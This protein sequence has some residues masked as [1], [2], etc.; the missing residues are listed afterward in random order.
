MNNTPMKTKTTKQKSKEPFVPDLIAYSDLQPVHVADVKDPEFVSGPFRHDCKY[1][2]S[3]KLDGQGVTFWCGKNATVSAI[4]WNVS[5]EASDAVEKWLRVMRDLMPANLTLVYDYTLQCLNKVA[6]IERRARF[7]LSD[8]LEGYAIKGEVVGPGIKGNRYGLTV[9]QFFVFDVA[10]YEPSFD[11][12]SR[13]RIFYCA[14]FARRALVDRM[15]L[16]NVPLTHN[17]PFHAFLEPR[18]TLEEERIYAL[19]SEARGKSALGDCDREGVVL[20]AAGMGRLAWVI[21]SATG[22]LP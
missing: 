1:E 8:V 3:E 12:R 22:V 10:W 15:C 14:P 16:T 17:C 11:P 13:D 20:K 21:N 9:H 2:A 18:P 4:T 19:E 5:K 7:K 6:R